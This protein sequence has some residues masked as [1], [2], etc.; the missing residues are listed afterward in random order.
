MSVCDLVIILDG[1]GDGVGDKFP[2]GLSRPSEQSG[3]G[4][5]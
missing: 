2:T 4:T 5:K 3:L 1:A